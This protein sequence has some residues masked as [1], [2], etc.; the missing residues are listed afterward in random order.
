MTVGVHRHLERCVPSNL[1][2]GSR[3]YPELEQYGHTPM[4]EVVQPHDSNPCVR[5]CV[6]NQTRAVSGVDR[7]ANGRGEHETEVRPLL[8]QLN[9]LLLLGL[10]VLP[11]LPKHFNDKLWQRDSPSRPLRFRRHFHEVAAHPLQAA[12]NTRGLDLEVDVR[13]LQ[14]KDFA[15]PHSK[16]REHDKHREYP[17][18]TVCLQQLPDLANAQRRRLLFLRTAHLNQLCRVLGDQLLA[19]RIL[20]SGAQGGVGV[21]GL[22]RA[23]TPLRRSPSK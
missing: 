21:L 9:A 1:H 10:P 15:A 20:Q 12:D 13:P 8:G 23:P 7:C 18:A 5:A 16:E 2:R 11:V 3:G 19:D 6:L 22:A 4:S 14:T 17:L